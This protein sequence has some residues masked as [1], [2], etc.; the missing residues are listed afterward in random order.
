MIPIEATAPDAGLGFACLIIVMGAMLWMACSKAKD[1]C[2]HRYERVYLDS[3]N[4]LVKKTRRSTGRERHYHEWYGSDASLSCSGW[5][6]T[7][8][9]VSSTTFSRAQRHDGIEDIRKMYIED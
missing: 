7:D 6:E 9:Y 3:R 8:H 4:R 5:W 2:L 1:S